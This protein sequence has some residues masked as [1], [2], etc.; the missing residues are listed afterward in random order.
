M[1]V[2]TIREGVLTCLRSG[3]GMAQNDPLTRK[4]MTWVHLR[5]QA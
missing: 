1:I 2:L 5:L 3:N 4:S